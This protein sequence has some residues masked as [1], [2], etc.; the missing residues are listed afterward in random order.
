METQKITKNALMQKQMIST[1]ERRA[2][3]QFAGRN[4]QHPSSSF[5]EGLGCSPSFAIPLD[6][7]TL[8]SQLGLGPTSVDLIFYTPMLQILVF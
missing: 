3:H 5:G 7:W 2:E 6:S 4:T 1:S 8:E